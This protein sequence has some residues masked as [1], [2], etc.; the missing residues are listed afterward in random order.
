MSNFLK[1]VEKVLAHEGGFVNHPLDRGGATNW[2]ITQKT[3]SSY[4]NR[5]VSVDYVKNLSRGNAISIYK[6]LYWDKVRGDD[7]NSYAIAFTLFDQAVNRGI[8]SAVKQAQTILRLSSDGI[9]GTNTVNALNSVNE[10]EFLADY[11]AACEAW[12]RR[13]VANNPSQKV[14]LAGWLNRVQSMRDYLGVDGALSKVLYD[15]NDNKKLISSV[16]IIIG[17]VG[18]LAYKRMA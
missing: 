15:I 5:S 1:A 10:K 16:I 3:L 2:G 7:I 18:F 4:E 17:L 8:S 11:L 14:F 9:M 12:Y 6:A 13:I